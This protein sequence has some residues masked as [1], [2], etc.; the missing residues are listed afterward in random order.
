M[1]DTI[2][3]PDDDGDLGKKMK[4]KPKRNIVKKTHMED[5][6]PVYLQVCSISLSTV[7]SD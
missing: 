7:V 4:Q 2:M 3:L 6:Y 5:N 1:V